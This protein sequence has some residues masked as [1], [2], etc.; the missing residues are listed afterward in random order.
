VIFTHRLRVRYGECDPQGIVFNANYLLYTDVAFTEFW[1]EA[2]GPWQEMVQSGVDLVVAETILRF[3][4]PARFDDEIDVRVRLDRLGD[5]SITTDLD[6]MRGEELLV[7]VL[8]RHV[9]V[10]T[11]SGVGG[12]SGLP[13]DVRST[14]LPGWV[15]VGLEPFVVPASGQQA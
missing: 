15:R 8:A 4:S 11:S 3:H 2:L 6:V 14:P 12:E 13:E 7:T 9:C 1:R 5:S 10:A